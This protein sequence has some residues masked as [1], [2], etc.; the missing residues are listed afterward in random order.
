M[1]PLTDSPQDDLHPETPDVAALQRR[2]LLTAALTL[3]TWVVALVVLD[4]LGLGPLF[5]VLAAVVIY[6]VVVRP[7][8]RPVRDAVRL[9]RRLAH[10]AW[11][12]R[13]DAG[14]LG[15]EDDRG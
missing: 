5:A 3:G 7:L 8:M 4:A 9:R 10:Q 13:R 15:P 14:E 1:S 6:V 12:E 11:L 2:V